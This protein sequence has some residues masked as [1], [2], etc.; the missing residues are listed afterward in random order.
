[1]NQLYKCKG[2]HVESVDAKKEKNQGCFNLNKK[3]DLCWVL[4]VNH[5]RVVN[6]KFGQNKVDKGMVLAL[7]ATVLFC[8]NEYFV[9]WIIIDFF[10][11]ILLNEK[12]GYF[13]NE[14][15]VEWIIRIL[16][17]M[18]ILW[19]VIL[20]IQIEWMNQI[21]LFLWKSNMD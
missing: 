8:L 4:K 7:F 21:S 10:M 3:H 2:G 16:F 14:Y 1:M 11:N 18:N 12:S 17:W 5:E 9:E 20:Q 13:F 19:I 15:F 6:S